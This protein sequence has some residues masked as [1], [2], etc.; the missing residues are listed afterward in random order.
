MHALARLTKAAHRLSAACRRWEECNDALVAAET[1]VEELQD[2]LLADYT[3]RLRKRLPPFL[4]ARQTLGPSRTVTVTAAS[5]PAPQPYRAWASPPEAAPSGELALHFRYMRHVFVCNVYHAGY[6]TIY[7]G[8]PDSV[9]QELHEDVYLRQRISG[10]CRISS[11]LR[12][13]LS[14]AALPDHPGAP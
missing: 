12:E 5:T 3:A 14:L 9:T 13:S 4:V 6:A 2:E 7:R 11:A 10:W 8:C 1:K